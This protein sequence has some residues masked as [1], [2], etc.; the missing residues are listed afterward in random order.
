[1]VPRSTYAGVRCS[2]GQPGAQPH[3]Q[4]HVWTTVVAPSCQAV[5]PARSQTQAGI[6]WLSAQCHAQNA[7]PSELHNSAS[8]VTSCNRLLV[9]GCRGRG[10]V[11]RPWQPE[12]R[13]HHRKSPC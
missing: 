4:L 13:T 12:L 9:S 3:D 10:Q 7:A 1:M 2:R 6:N 5:I 8:G 11:L